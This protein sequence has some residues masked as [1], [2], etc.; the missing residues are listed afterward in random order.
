MA[1]TAGILMGFIA[2]ATNALR[3]KQRQNRPQDDN[4]GIVQLYGSDSANIE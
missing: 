1:E 2:L 4:S 3:R